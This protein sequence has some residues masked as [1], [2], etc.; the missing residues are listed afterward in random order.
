M[1]VDGA[2][3]E[4]AQ[5]KKKKVVKKHE[6]PFVWGHS[7]LDASIIAQFRE[8]EAQMHAADKLVFDTEVGDTIFPWY[9]RV[10]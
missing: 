10:F 5:P 3:G 6:V 9:S 7:G 1:Q 8:L 4:A 2:E